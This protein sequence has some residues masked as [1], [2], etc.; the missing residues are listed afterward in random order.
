[1]VKECE[2]ARDEGKYLFMWDKAGSVA[3]FFQYKGH[4]T[5]VQ[6]EI[7]RAKIGG[8]DDLSGA[9]ELMRKDLVYTMRAGDNHLIDFG[10]LTPDFSKLTQEGVFNPELVFNRTEWIK[11]DNYIQFVK[12]DEMHGLGGLNPGHYNMDDAKWTLSF[13]SEAATADEV[14]AIVAAMPNSDQFK[15]CIVE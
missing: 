10:K 9:C 14:A 13:R 12:D 5:E 6:K 1:M 2:K 7:V 8:S 15:V 11:K 3:T 4:L